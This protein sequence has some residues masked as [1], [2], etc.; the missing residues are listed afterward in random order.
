MKIYNNEIECGLK[1]KILSSARFSVACKITNSYS[2]DKDIKVS[3][4][5]ANPDQKDLYYIDSLLVSSGWNGNDDVFLKNYLWEARHTPED[6]KLNFMHNE[7]DIIGH[8]TS[9]RVIDAFGNVI[10]DN[11]DVNSLPDEIHI[12][13]GSV[14]YK[15]WQDEELQKRMDTMIAE[16]K[17]GKWAVSMECIFTDFDYALIKDGEKLVV[18]RNEDS[19]YLTK[20]LRIYGGSGTY[21]GYRVGRVLKNFSFSGNG[22]VDIPANPNSVIFGLSDEKELMTFANYKTN[23][24]KG[25]RTIMEIKLEDHLNL[26]NE[27]ATSKA[28]AEVLKSRVEDMQKAIASVEKENKELS[29]KLTEAV[30]KN[31][32]VAKSLNSEKLAR[33]EITKAKDEEI[34]KLNETISSITSE[35]EALAAKVAEA[36][37][38]SKTEARKAKLLAKVDEA[39]ATELVEKFKEVSD[40]LFD[41]FVSNISQAECMSDEEKKKKMEAEKKQKE[42]EALKKAE[43]DLEKAKAE[44][45]LSGGNDTE[46]NKEKQVSIARYL[47]GISKIK[48]KSGE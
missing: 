25:E 12:V 44:A 13:V 46:V 2:V 28:G 39:K 16:I 45:G 30:A 26:V 47:A 22:I 18:E 38:F 14:M 34:S 42:A 29:E 9:A 21:D 36:E 40:E 37:E 43:E 8:Q 33:E 7:K 5:R 41:V 3:V 17:E 48:V 10:S 23:T 1:D 15:Y 27:A 24:D 32:E 19:S 6:K 11:E 31:E 20:A 35:K 4:A